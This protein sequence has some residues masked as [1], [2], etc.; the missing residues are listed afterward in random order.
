MI[1]LVPR[2][3]A[4]RYP[5]VLNNCFGRFCDDFSEGFRNENGLYVFH[6]RMSEG[7]LESIFR[8]YLSLELRRIVNDISQTWPTVVN[9]RIFLVFG[10]DPV[11]DNERFAL[12]ESDIRIDM[13]KL[14]RVWKKIFNGWFKAKKD[15]NL[16]FISNN[17]LRSS[18]ICNTIE[19]VFGKGSFVNCSRLVR[20]GH[21]DVLIDRSE[22]DEGTSL[23]KERLKLVVKQAKD[24]I[25]T[26][27]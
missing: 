8:E 10:R 22:I 20:S 6:K 27:I 3:F 1:D 24:Y 26:C 12:N 7:K 9:K 19:L 15:N 23:D 16:F 25:Q 2:A 4:I 14:E 18:E 5:N 17:D 13:A 11:D 21:K